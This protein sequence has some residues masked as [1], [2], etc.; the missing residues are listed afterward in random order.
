MY[1]VHCQPNVVETLIV[2]AFAWL[3]SK[4]MMIEG[5]VRSLHHHHLGEIE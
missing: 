4:E 5:G 1:L 3:W 2:R